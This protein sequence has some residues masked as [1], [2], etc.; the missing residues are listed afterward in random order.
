[1][2]IN[3]YILLG[4][5]FALLT[6]SVSMAD[7]A[8]EKTDVHGTNPVLDGY[9]GPGGFGGGG[10]HGGNGNMCRFGCC[11]AR[12]RRGFCERCCLAAETATTKQ[13]TGQLQYDGGYGGGGYGGGHY[14]GGNYC[15]F[16]CCG[17]RYGGF[18]RRCC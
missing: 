8:Q 3:G 1:M 6:S 2:K 14:G 17:S 11:G 7:E 13:E 4:L 12:P 15:R 9:G 10:G 5:L 16:G 18:C